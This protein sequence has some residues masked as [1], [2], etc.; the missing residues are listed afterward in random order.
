MNTETLK[1]YESLK[2]KIKTLEAQ[3]AVIEPDVKEMLANCG[4]DQIETDK[5]KFYF[6][7]R[8]S[9]KYS[10]VVKTKEVEVKELKK[11][12]E[13]TGVATF[14]ESKSLTYRVNNAPSKSEDVKS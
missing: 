2:L 8:K 5:G 7:M 1:E 9:W 3:L 10:D 4:A 14:E 11:E 6:T 13:K 12:E